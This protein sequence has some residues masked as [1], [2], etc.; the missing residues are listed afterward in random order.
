MVNQAAAQETSPVLDK[1]A[2]LKEDIR[3]LGRLLGDVL[4]DQEG[5]EVFNVVETIRQTAVRFRRED[6]A[7]AGEELTTLLHKLSRNQTISVVR[8]F[9]YFSHLA[10][11]AEDQHHIRR[12]RAH[13][14]AGSA[15]QQGSVSFALKK[16]RQAGVEGETV[17]EFF[18]EALIAPVLTAHPTEV[19]R[20]SILDA[21]HDIARLLAERDLPLTPKER[22]ANTDLL[23][24]RIATLWQTRMLRYSKLTVADEID[25]ALSYYR[26]TFLRELPGLYDDIEQEI[27]EQYPGEGLA[28]GNARY[29]QMGS[30]IGGDRDGNP[31][32]NAGTMQHALVRQA[33][34]IL[35][36]YLEEVHALGAELSISTL[37]VGASPELQALADVS[38]DHSPHRS[39]E[40]YRRALIG[41]YARLAA[42]ARALGAT[43]ILRK[44]V[45]HAEPYAQASDFADD[46]KILAASLRANHGALLVKPRL[47]TL[48]RASG[49]FG[50]HLASLDMR[51]SSD[52]HER[53]LAELF[54][55]AGVQASY[56]QLDEAQKVELLLAELAQPRLLYS[57]YAKYSAEADS[58][59]SI[60]RAARDIRARY[61]VRAIRNYIISHTETVSDLL[62]VLLLQKETGLLRT[63]A[64]EL[65]AMVIPLFETIPDLQRAA[66]I[67][68]EWMA[69]PM[70]KELI[71]KQGMLQEVMLGYSDSNKDGGF[72]TSNWELY[73]AE[74]HLVKVFAE[75]GVKIRL[76]HGRGGT[77]GRGGGP[78]Y[79]AILAQPPGTVNGQIR[80]TEQGEIIASK[81]SNA[82]IG[83]R[84]LELLVAATLEATL[85]PHA[86]EGD[87]A[88]R[89][90]GFEDIMA[91]LS[92]RAYKAYRNLVY[93][94]PGFTDYFFS[95]TPIA[96]IAELNLGSR[97]ASRK[98]TKRIEDLRAIPWGFSWGQCRL[99]LPGW[100]GFGS[101][102]TQWIEEGNRDE[103]IATLQAMFKE[104]P[105]FATL[106]S[107]M[108]MVLAKTDLA[109]ASRYAELVADVE[110]RERIFKRIAAEHGT[111][112]RCLEAITGAHERLAGNPLLARS[113]QNRFAYLDPLN[114]LQVELIHRHRKVAGDPAQIDERVHR[115]IHLSINGVAAGLRNTG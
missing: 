93:E 23:H 1:D 44:E 53:V 103:K 3:L 105:F 75:A 102:I 9:S 113:I 59:L 67:M 66:A 47:A 57:P 34:T 39:D 71:A 45:G 99:L 46:L 104:W 25:N 97:P 111:T 63:Q 11:I 77:V 16:L 86:A 74:I 42:T 88:Q 112:L 10:N 7:A 68:G 49:I 100:Y 33:T 73:K 94:T 78:S 76:F 32:V 91:D 31:N 51:Q 84:N 65:D 5:E 18:K 70:V 30:W 28:L 83:R 98:S 43:N 22:L 17:R 8:A 82:E 80:L 36:F 60:L 37:M 56:A 41:I 48:L 26:I 87:K 79:E 114:H 52:V 58:E 40:P 92:A 110:L 81:F 54:A 15:P 50:F 109:I 62:E 115:G 24:A 72:L 64:G 61:G 90:A 35:D 4:R 89:L 12:R 85:T 27:A 95:A 108:D 21:E 101:A 20:K 13:L 19:Q 2:P 14:L 69:I 29:V 106:L 107:N 38:P 55:S 96:E 6:D